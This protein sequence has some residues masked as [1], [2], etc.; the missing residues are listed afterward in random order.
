MEMKLEITHVLET[1][2]KEGTLNSR[3]AILNLPSA[4]LCE[5]RGEFVLYNGE[6]KQACEGC[7][8]QGLALKKALGVNQI[9][10][11]IDYFSRKYQ[12]RFITINGRGDPL[13]PLL[14][15][16]NLQK[17]KY[18]FDKYKI[19]TYLFTAGQNLDSVTVK[20]LVKNKVNVI[21]S[22]FGNKFI[23]ADFFSGKEY[24]SPKPPLQNEQTIA[25]NLRRL[26]AAYK[27]QTDLPFGITR[28]G[29][30]YVLT[31]RDI[32]DGFIQ[33]KALKEAANKNGVSFV[34]N[35]PFLKNSDPKIQNILETKSKELSN[36]H[37]PHTTTVEGYC[38][39]GAG[40]SATIDY[41]GMLLRCPYLSSALGQ[42]YFH[43]LLEGE[44]DAL[45]HAYMTERTYPCVMRKFEKKVIE[46]SN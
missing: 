16:L 13:H 8:T 24:A 42:G 27:D 40:S 26:I 38:Q 22:L 14:R 3:L 11:I 4:N 35:I 25:E 20:F 12:T 46:K 37:L 17:I 32:E 43:E 6:R 31:V 19:Q 9:L 41:D 21:I 15:E 7:I 45:L 18:S 28:I 44:K 33:V 30:N 1:L 36:F 34:C 5:K 23:D 10:P 39:M 2:S 29:M